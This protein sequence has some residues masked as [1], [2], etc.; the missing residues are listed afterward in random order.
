MFYIRLWIAGR[1]AFPE[2]ISQETR[3][4]GEEAARVTA[5]EEAGAGFLWLACDCENGLKN[6][7]LVR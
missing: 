7:T 3:E 4:A 5:R 6:R 2:V 1:R